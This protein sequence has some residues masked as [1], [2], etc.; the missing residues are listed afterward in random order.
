MICENE[1][2]IAHYHTGGVPGRHE[3]DETQQLNYPGYYASDSGDRLPGQSRQLAVR[4]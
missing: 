1:E 3:I 4:V 2:R